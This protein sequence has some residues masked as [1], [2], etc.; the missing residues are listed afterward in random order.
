MRIKFTN[1]WKNWSMT[2]RSWALIMVGY[3][4]GIPTLDN[5]Y[6]ALPRYIYF[7]LLGFGFHL[8]LGEPK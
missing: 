5:D 3:F 7:V 1:D 6:T 8:E 4:G 2:N